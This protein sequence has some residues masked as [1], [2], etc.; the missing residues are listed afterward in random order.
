[1]AAI[2]QRVYVCDNCGTR[3]VV[4][5]NGGQNVP[6]RHVVPAGW[7]HYRPFRAGF[8][9]CPACAPLGEEHFAATK[10]YDAA[11]RAV[12]APL[13]D[14]ARKAYD[15]VTRPLDEWAAA[16]PAPRAPWERP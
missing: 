10:V 5:S 12:A 2:F 14:A 3:A 1:M 15:E 11:R 8:D 16:N 7:L 4:E 9:L 6:P 13:Y